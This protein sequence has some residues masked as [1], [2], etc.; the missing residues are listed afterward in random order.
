MAIP[1]S[2]KVDFKAK[3]ITE[4]QEGHHVMTL[5]TSTSDTVILNIHIQ[6]FL[7]FIFSQIEFMFTSLTNS[8]YSPFRRTD[9]TELVFTLRFLERPWFHRVCH[10]SR[11]S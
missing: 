4:D 9:R 1:I 8:K 7:A 6:H 2:H 10:S 3:K 5:K 11:G